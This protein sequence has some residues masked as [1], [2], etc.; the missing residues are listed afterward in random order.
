MDGKGAFDK[1]MRDGV[2]NPPD[3]PRAQFY[4]FGKRGSAAHKRIEHRSL[5][6]ANGLIEQIEDIRAGRRECGNRHGTEHRAQALRPPF[7]DM[8]A[9]AV[10]FLAPAFLLGDIA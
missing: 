8:G 5:G 1:K 6:D 7:M 10:D 3:G 4:R 9:R 2:D